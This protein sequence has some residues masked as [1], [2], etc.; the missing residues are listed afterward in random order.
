[1]KHLKWS[2]SDN[3]RDYLEEEKGEYDEFNFRSSIRVTADNGYTK[4]Y[5][6]YEVKQNAKEQKLNEI[7]ANITKLQITGVAGIHKKLKYIAG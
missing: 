2:V 3:S 6:I 7:Y 4:T 5:R 1:M